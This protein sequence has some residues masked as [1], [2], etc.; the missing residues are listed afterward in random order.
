MIRQNGHQDH[1]TTFDNQFLFSS[2]FLMKITAR[3]HFQKIKNKQNKTKNDRYK[4]LDKEE[5]G[6][7]FYLMI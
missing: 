7:K 6:L 3:E 2:L 1:I 4:K 5:L